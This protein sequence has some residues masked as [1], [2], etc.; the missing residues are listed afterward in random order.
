M[1]VRPSEQFK[2]L[3]S[4]WSR[5]AQIAFTAAPQQHLLPGHKRPFSII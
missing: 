5:D 1:E 3:C 4:I 2:D